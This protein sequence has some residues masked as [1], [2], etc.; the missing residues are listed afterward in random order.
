MVAFAENIYLW[1]VYRGLSQDELAVRSGIPRPNISAIES[2]KRE[3]SLSTLRSLAAGLRTSPGTLV[4]GIAPARF[5]G[6]LLSRESL[7]AIVKASLGR[8]IARI[9]PQQKHISVILSGMIKNRVNANNARY[10]NILT[11]RHGY[12]DNWLML[13]AGI[14]RASVNSLLARLDKYLELSRRDAR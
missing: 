13:K 2:G 9:T 11:G 4:N 8:P 3:V 7:E 1:R 14:G 6:V 12:V 5:K 10:R